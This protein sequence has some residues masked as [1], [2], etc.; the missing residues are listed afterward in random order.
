[1]ITLSFIINYLK[2]DMKI[3]KTCHANKL[4]E[5]FS[6]KIKKSGTVCRDAHCKN[7]RASQM[8]QERKNNP[9]KVR[10][11]A[12]ESRRKRTDEQK[13]R[14]SAYMEEWRKNNPD[15]VN[16]IRPKELIQKY[17]R[18][19]YEKHKERIKATVSVY[20][21]E[22]LA[23]IRVLNQSRRGLE[24]SGKLSANIIETLLKKQKGLCVCCK[25][26]LNNDFHV[27]HIIPFSLGGTNTDD[28][29]QLLKSKCNLQKHSKHPIDFMREK[30]YL[31]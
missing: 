4:L 5:D 30:G 23:R 19:Y 27:D 29:V 21:K 31:L 2:A 16:P 26:K 18:T 24:R 14:Q 6:P 28:N 10:A 17:S 13:Q 22:N 8:R 15:K 7:C 11:L 25:T 12:T 20:R 1:M 3:C 9:G